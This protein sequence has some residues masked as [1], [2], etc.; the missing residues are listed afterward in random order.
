MRFRRE[1]ERR[2]TRRTDT[3]EDLES[4]DERFTGG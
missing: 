2:E 1:R 4:R 3:Y